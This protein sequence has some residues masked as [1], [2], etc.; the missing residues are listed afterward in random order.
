MSNISLGGLISGMDTDTM[1]EKIMDVERIRALR[2]ES[3]VASLAAVQSAWKEVK[4]SLQSLRSSLDGIRLASTFEARKASSSDDSVATVSAAAGSTATT[5]TLSVTKLAQTHVVA[6]A[7]KADANTALLAGPTSASI[8]IDVKGKAI[9]VAL[10]EKDTLNSLR[11]KIN[12]AAGVN[13]TAELVKVSGGSRLVLTSKES[14]AAGEIKITAESGPPTL[15]TDLGL[16]KDADGVYVNT[17]VA[18]QDATFT[19]DGQSYSRSTNIVTDTVPGLTITLKKGGTKDGAGVVTP[20]S[21]TVTI[22]QDQDAVVSAV[23]KW[24]SS[25]N[26]TLNLLKERT[27]YDPATKKAGILNGDSLAR[28][29]QT[30]LRSMLST[31]VAGLPATLNKL[32]QIGVTTGQWGADDYGKVKVDTEKLKSMLSQDPTGV[33]KLFGAVRTNVALSTGGATATSDPASETATSSPSD[34]I[35]GDIDANR[36]GSYG[37]GWQSAAAPSTGSQ[38]LTVSFNGTKTIDQIRLYIPDTAKYPASTQGLQNYIVEYKGADDQWHTI[39]SVTNHTGASRL[40]EFKA[41]Q[42]KAVRLSV[43]A[44][45]GDAPARVSELQIN[46]VNNGTGANMFRLVNDALTSTTGPLDTRD[47]TLTD[48]IN[49]INKRVESINARLV[50]REEQLRAQFLRMEQ[51][52]AQ[53]QSQGS[54]IISL[55]TSM[56]NNNNRK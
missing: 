34:V 28:R 45:Y 52:M 38:K 47:T 33:A 14:G 26:A 5:H 22:A 39:E 17:V 18:Y 54:A 1:V 8:K 21:T 25:L 55:M 44:T 49:E 11:D 2:E 42:A 37:G 24:A 19:L 6:T 46:E 48:Q 20:V 23:N 13:V 36:F 43:T 10:T 31:E 41:A 35:N 7:T 32:S 15:L 30:S 9:T 4:G 40:F 3:R 51:A 50:K 53:I 12:S 27:Q 16:D 56:N 29:L